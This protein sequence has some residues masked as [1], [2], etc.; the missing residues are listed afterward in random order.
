MKPLLR[1]ALALLS[2]LSPVAVRATD[3]VFFIP[4]RWSAAE[5]ALDPVSLAWLKQAPVAV[6]IYPQVSVPPAAEPL[7]ASTVN[8]RAQYSGKII[9]LHLEWPDAKPARDRTVGK[10]SD[11]AAVQWPVRYGPGV[12]LPYIGMGHSG[13]PVALWF[14]R[15]DGAVETLAAQGFGTLTTQAADGIKA[16]GIWKDGKWYVVF[17]R[18]LAASGE[19]HGSL[20]PTK[21]GLAPV[22]FAIWNG[23]SAERNGLKRLSAW[24]TLRFERG[25]ASAAYAKQL[26]APAPAGSVENGKRL[27]AEKGCAGCHAYPGNP[28]RPSIGPDLTYAGG[29]HATDYLLESLSDPSRVVVP[30]K[31][32]SLVQDGKRLSLMP[33]FAGTD[34]ERRDI[35]M[36]LKTLR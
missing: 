19:H 4:V 24:Q 23:D 21:L 34:T 35:V 15:A 12:A 14:W 28:V 3:G 26:A 6:A 36:F 11:G 22:A 8:V 32:F 17:T 2:A 25:A 27:M 1:L 18:S 30:G 29:I 31:T 20:A 10:F 7:G 9:A 5:P 33:P 13:A 16:K